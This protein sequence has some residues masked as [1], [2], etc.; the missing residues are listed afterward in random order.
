MSG[1]LGGCLPNRL[2]LLRRSG[3]ALG[4]SPPVPPGLAGHFHLLAQMKV[5]KAKCLNASDPTELHGKK[6]RLMAMCSIPSF[7]RPT[8]KTCGKRERLDA[9]GQH[10]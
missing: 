9:T 8:Q 2:L 5:T 1:R 4:G 6:V 10:P 3:S 7:A